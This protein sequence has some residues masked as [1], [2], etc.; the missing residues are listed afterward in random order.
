MKIPL[1]LRTYNSPFKPLK[2]KWYFGKVTQGVPIFLPRKWIKNKERPG[3]LKAVPIKFGFSCCR[4]G[5]KTKYDSYRFEFSPV[6]SFVAFGYQITLTFVA[7]NEDAY[8]E[9]FLAYYYDTDKK[10]SIRERL[11]YCIKKYPQTWTMHSADKKE[12]TDYWTK[13]LKEKWKN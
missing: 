13:I 3:F 4:L 2:L 5:W 12:T 10:L 9:S 1:Y 7:E 8:W 6:W 11:D